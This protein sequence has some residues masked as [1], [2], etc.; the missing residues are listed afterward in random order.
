MPA[1]SEGQRRLA[2][3]AL[4]IKRGETPRSYSKE[5]AKMADTMTEKQLREY[6]GSVKKKK[7]YP[8]VK[9]K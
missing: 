2:G 3:I 9:G 5:A 8:F 1:I 7:Q 6:A 4:A